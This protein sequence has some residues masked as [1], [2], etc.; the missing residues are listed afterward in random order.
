VKTLSAEYITQKESFPSTAA[1]SNQS[2]ILMHISVTS[3]TDNYITENDYGTNEASN[4]FSSYKP[5]TPPYFCVTKA[6]V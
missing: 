2:A 3:K 4:R 6:A 5:E 1:I